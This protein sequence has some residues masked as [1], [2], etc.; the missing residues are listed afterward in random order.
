MPD[1]AI[2]RLKDKATVGD[3]PSF[4]NFISWK[5]SP[6]DIVLVTLYAYADLPI[7]K[8]FNCIFNYNNPEIFVRAEFTISHAILFMTGVF[9]PF[10]TIGNGHKHICVLT[11]KDHIPDVF[12]TI[13]I[14]DS[15]LRGDFSRQLGLCDYEN[16]G[17]IVEYMNAI[18]D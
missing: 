6:N 14:T 13:G 18:R 8:N 7:P 15:N 1:N 10:E 3:A 11:F 4:L 12:Q 9:A 17:S 16:L 5:K 2:K